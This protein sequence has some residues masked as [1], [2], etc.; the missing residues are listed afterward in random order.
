MSQIKTEKHFLLLDLGYFRV[1]LFVQGYLYC[2]GIYY[3]PLIDDLSYLLRGEDGGGVFIWFSVI[4]LSML[5]FSVI[6]E[7]GSCS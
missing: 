7:I 5:G 4:S 1:H 2:C 3:T 6:K